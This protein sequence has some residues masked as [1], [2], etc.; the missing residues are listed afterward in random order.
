MIDVREI[1]IAEAQDGFKVGKFSAKELARAFFDR[2]AKW[3]KNGPRINSTMALSPTALKEAAALDD[4]L[5]ETGQFKGK[6]HGIP[7][8]VKDQVWAFLP[9]VKDHTA[10]QT[11]LMC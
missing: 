11:C 4:Y 7:V 3:D 10:D 2:I 6:L 1:T 9:T 5:K 8:L